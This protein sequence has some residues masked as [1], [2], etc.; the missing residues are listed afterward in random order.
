[1]QN[2]GLCWR[3]HLLNCHNV[4][5]LGQIENQFSRSTKS[6]CEPHVRIPSARHL[7]GPGLQ[8]A[9]LV[10][11]PSTTPSFFALVHHDAAPSRHARSLAANASKLHA[12]HI[13]ARAHPHT[14]T[15]TKHTWLSP[16]AGAD[17]KQ[18]ASYPICIGTYLASLYRTLWICSARDTVRTTA[19]WCQV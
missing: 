16:L 3:S 14:H 8:P 2:R 17:D 10:T 19:L 4:V 9:L 15:H 7:A 5:R 11:R 12:F 1:M 18:H 13:P 6:T